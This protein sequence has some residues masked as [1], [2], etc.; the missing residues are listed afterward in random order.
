MW[1]GQLLSEALNWILKHIIKEE[2]PNGSNLHLNGYGFPSSHSQYM[3][4]FG[5]FLICH[6]YFRH[7]F[8]SCGYPLLDQAFRFIVYLGVASWTVLVAYSRLNLLYHT[9]HQVIWGLGIGISHGAVHYVL[10][11]LL[12]HTRPHSVFGHARAAILAHPV[13]IWMQIRDGW[14]MW[15]DGGRETEWKH[16]K[17]A[18]DERRTRLAQKRID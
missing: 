7:R 8:T 14:A 10:T 18:Y 12:P 4:Y 17:T 16:W 9:P 13:V 1:A 6:M 15:A 11:E 3:G 5:A 2:R